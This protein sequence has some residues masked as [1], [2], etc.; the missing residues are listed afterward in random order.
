MIFYTLEGQMKNDIHLAKGLLIKARIARQKATIEQE[1]DM[2]FGDGQ[3]NVDNPEA[4][5][6]EAR[7][8]RLEAQELLRKVE[9]LNGQ[10]YLAGEKTFSLKDH[11]KGSFFKAWK[12]FDAEYAKIGAPLFGSD[13][14]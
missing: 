7:A 3:D 11:L 4:L 13:P 9:K 10:R 2:Y 1:L 6:A 14:E 12:E 8:L 5:L